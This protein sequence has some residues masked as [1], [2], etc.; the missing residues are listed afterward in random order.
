MSGY[1]IISIYCMHVYAMLSLYLVSFCNCAVQD[2]C[3]PCHNTTFGDEDKTF[4]GL[5]AM[6]GTMSEFQ[7]GGK[8]S[9][10]IYAERL[11]HY[12]VANKVTEAEQKRTI[13][14]S[15]CGPTTFK[16]IKS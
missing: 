14:L 5:M 4:R 7:P 6:H 15:V 9:W 8:E 11:G 10:S 13:L 2:A 16:L 12:F 1:V 3:P